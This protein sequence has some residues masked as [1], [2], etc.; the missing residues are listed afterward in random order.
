MAR[1]SAIALVAV[2]GRLFSLSSS[3][4]ALMPNGVAALPRPIMLAAMLRIIALIAGL[5]SGTSGKSRRMT[6]RTARAMVAIR[7]PF[8]ATRI[9][10]RKNAMTPTSPMARSTAFRADERIDPVRILHAARG[11]GQEHRGE[12]NRDEK[13]VQ[14]WAGRAMGDRSRS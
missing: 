6:G 7:P 8:S 10:P 2:P 1:N 3:W 5:S 13:T 14:H 4:I 12:G 9:N 11:R